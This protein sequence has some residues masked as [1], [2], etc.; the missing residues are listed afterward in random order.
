MADTCA[1]PGC[2]A[3]ARTRDFCRRHYKKALRH[4]TIPKLLKPRPPHCQVDGCDK[5]VV[6][7]GFCNCHYK[8]WM[9]FGDPICGVFQH[10]DY[11]T[12]TYEAWSHMVQ[13][14]TDKH[15]PNF[16]KY[17]GRTHADGTPNPVKV[18]D[19][20]RD[21][22]AFKTYLIES[23][24][25]TRETAEQARGKTL[26]LDRYPCCEGD[27]VPGNVRWASKQEQTENRTITRWLTIDGLRKPVSTWAK[28]FGLCPST[29]FR[30]LNRG[31]NPK[32]A[33]G[34]E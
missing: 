8:H 32:R 34:L 19:A 24:L 12:R 3:P 28:L 22:R 10:G 13:R 11:G 17:G 5:P 16:A 30:R 2:D 25:G 29:V 23:G 6:A 9:Q 7:K 14:C 20:W 27:Y 26:S 21:Y 15:C 4:G 33:L 1:E 18:H 31:W